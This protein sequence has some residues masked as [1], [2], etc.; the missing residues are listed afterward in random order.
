M[1]LSIKSMMFDTLRTNPS[2][3][4][5]MEQTRENCLKA[6][7]KNPDVLAY[8]E[9][10]TEEICE[11]AII[12]YPYALAHVKNQSLRL[13]YLAFCGG[14]SLDVVRN[15]TAE[16]CE[17]ALEK[18]IRNFMYVDLRLQ[19]QEM[20]DN[21]IR[22]DPSMLEFAKPEFHTPDLLDLAIKHDGCNI[23]HAIDLPDEVY[24]QAV[25]QNILAFMYLPEHLITQEL[26]YRYVSHRG[27]ELECIPEEYRTKE[28]YRMAAKAG[29][30]SN[31]PPEYLDD[32]MIIDAIKV[33]CNYIDYLN[34]PFEEIV[35]IAIQSNPHYLLQIENPTDEMKWLALKKD[36]RIIEHISNPDPEMIEYALKTNPV[37][38]I[39][40]DNM[41]SDAIVKAV[42]CDH[43]AIQS[44]EQTE[45]LCWEAI[46]AHPEAIA[47]ISQPTIEMCMYA[48]KHIHPSDRNE[49]VK[50]NFYY[51][52]ETYPEEYHDFAKMMYDR[53]P[54]LLSDMAQTAELVEYAVRKDPS[55]LIFVINQTDEIIDLAQSI[56]P[57]MNAIRDPVKRKMRT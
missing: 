42:R 11:L 4:A 6:V 13:C 45:E 33:D 26:C 17:V 31:I 38:A 3:F 8:I 35:M 30:I 37:V 36:P 51:L 27:V 55:A 20:C 28:L 44:V 14:C 22:K 53:Y 50:I 52:L 57:C 2:L 25:E 34:D 47:H 43:K 56:K 10:Q 54:T 48:L 49:L 21:V 9:D 19:T 16:I 18:N 12:S 46:R 15:Q 39:Y 29:N 41:P 1:I 5:T 23:A 40:L 32:S 7:A 24:L